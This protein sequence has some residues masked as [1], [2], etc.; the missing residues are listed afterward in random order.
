MRN[1][2]PKSLWT[3]ALVLALAVALAASPAA[4]R[5]RKG[6]GRHRGDHRGQE[7]RRGGDHHHH[8]AGCGH[9]SPVYYEGDHDDSHELFLALGLG[10]VGLTA[11]ALFAQP[12]RPAYGS[13]G[14]AYGGYAP[15]P[16][17]PA[18]APIDWNAIDDGVTVVSEGYNERGQFCREFQREIEVGGRLERGYGIACREADG[19]WRIGR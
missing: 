16:R 10:A 14:P 15:A 8:Y 9:G 2:A 12:P 4:A 6:Q 7:W 17:A 1:L 18:P 19:S 5:P 11:L 3:Q 13:Y